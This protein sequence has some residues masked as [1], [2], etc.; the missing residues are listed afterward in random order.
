[1]TTCCTTCDKGELTGLLEKHDELIIHTGNINN[2]APLKLRSYKTG[3]E[4]LADC[5]KLQ[6]ERFTVDALNNL[7]KYVS[8]Q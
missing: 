4:E 5:L 7:T 1:M 6:L 3:A 2:F 8:I